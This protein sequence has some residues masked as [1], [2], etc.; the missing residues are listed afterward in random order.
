M[1]GRGGGAQ[2]A[3]CACWRVRAT[4]CCSHG[5]QPDAACWGQ[6]QSHDLQVQSPFPFKVNS[7]VASHAG[8][9]DSHQVHTMKVSSLQTG[10]FREF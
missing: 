10:L 5:V 9:A 4:A 1:D 6:P 7:N 2:Q 8:S 3:A